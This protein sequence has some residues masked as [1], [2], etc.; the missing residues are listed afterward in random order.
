[1]SLEFFADFIAI[2]MLIKENNMDTDINTIKV[3]FCMVLP[4]FYICFSVLVY[5]VL[6]IRAIFIFFIIFVFLILAQ[7]VLNC[8]NR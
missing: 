8:Y 6:S 5:H 4:Q 2:I 1:M 3:I 7:I